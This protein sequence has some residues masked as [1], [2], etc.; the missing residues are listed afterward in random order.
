MLDIHRYSPYIIT[1]EIFLQ[2]DQSTIWSILSWLK[3]GLELDCCCFHLPAT[4]PITVS[5]RCVLIGK[6]HGDAKDT[7]GMTFQ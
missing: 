5:N 2:D 4:H 1:E 3:A 6:W 7:M